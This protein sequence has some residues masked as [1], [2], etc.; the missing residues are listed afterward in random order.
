MLVGVTDGDATAG[1]E[2]S[3]AAGD[4]YSNDGTGDPLVHPVYKVPGEGM[5]ELEGGPPAD[6][7]SPELKLSDAAKVTVASRR[8]L[9]RRPCDTTSPPWRRPAPLCMTHHA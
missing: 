2:G 9:G 5:A 7:I 8:A 1:G 6:R 3:A 4:M